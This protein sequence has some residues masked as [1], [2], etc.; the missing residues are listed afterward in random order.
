MDDGIASHPHGPHQNL[1]F[2]PIF[3]LSGIGLDLLFSAT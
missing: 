3:A 2:V 1:G